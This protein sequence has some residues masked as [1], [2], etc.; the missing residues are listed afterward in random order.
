MNKED[1]IEEHCRH[2]KGCESGCIDLDGD[3]LDKNV[4]ECMKQLEEKR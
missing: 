2:C 3:L 4:E 1:W